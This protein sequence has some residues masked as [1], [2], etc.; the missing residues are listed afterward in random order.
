MCLVCSSL[1]PQPL[2]LTQYLLHGGTLFFKEWISRL[3]AACSVS[4]CP[5]SLCA[6]RGAPSVWPLPV[7]PLRI[8]S[9]S[10]SLC[11]LYECSVQE[12]ERHST[13]GT[14]DLELRV[15]SAVCQ[16]LSLH[17]AS[18]PSSWASVSP[19]QSLSLNLGHPYEAS[20]RDM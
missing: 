4:S 14:S 2:L 13:L 6:G 19:F 18:T 10:S 11:S 3:I 12:K 5:A 17:A 9:L 20:S 16:A 1:Q 8:F 15:V 7:F